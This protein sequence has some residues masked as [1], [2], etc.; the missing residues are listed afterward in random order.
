MKTLERTDRIKT[1][2][3]VAKQALHEADN[4]TMLATD[5]EDVSSTANNLKAER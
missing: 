2:L 1:E 4:W 5:L 3:Q